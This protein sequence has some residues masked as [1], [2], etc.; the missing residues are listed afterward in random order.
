MHKKTIEFLNFLGHSGFYVFPIVSGICRCHSNIASISCQLQW[1]LDR[2][3]EQNL[4]TCALS[5]STQLKNAP[6]NQNKE[7]KNQP[8]KP[9]RN[10]IYAERSIFHPFPE[11]FHDFF[12]ND[13]ECNGIKL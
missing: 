8:E 13:Y 6:L 5:I 12:L 7:I 10:L 2:I 3:D 9:E 4:C 1:E 11:S